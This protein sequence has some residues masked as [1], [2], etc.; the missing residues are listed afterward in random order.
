M[1]KLSFIDRVELLDHDI[2]QNVIDRKK[3][4]SLEP[5]LVEYIVQLNDASSIYLKEGNIQRASQKLRYLHP[6]ISFRVAKERINDSINYFHLGNKVRKEAWHNLYADKYENLA[7]VAIKSREFKT[8]GKM[9]QLAHDAR[10]KAS[11]MADLTVEAPTFIFSTDIKTLGIEKKNLKEISSKASSGHYFEIINNLNI[12][13]EE[14][15]GL[16]EDAGITED[17]DFEEIKTDE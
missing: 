12:S 11:E 3:C 7:L 14:K 9:F 17:V 13:K 6:S 10:I 1:K 16:I 2:I 4:E 8:A 15:I 5:E